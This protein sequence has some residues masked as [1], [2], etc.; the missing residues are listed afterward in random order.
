[1]KVGRNALA[2]LSM[3]A[4]GCAAAGAQ[5]AEPS[6]VPFAAHYDAQ[7]KG[8]N[9]GSSE[10]ELK[11]GTE[12]GQFVYVWSIAARGIFKIAYNHP[13]N[14]SSWFSLQNGHVRPHKYLGEDGSAS[15]RLDFDW[16]RKLIT[17][18]SEHKP[19]NIPIK[20]G[21][22]DLNSIQVEVMLDLKGGDLPRTFEIIDKDQLKEF[23]YTREGTAR[24]RTEVGTLDTLVVASQRTGNTR[25]LRMWFA[26][27][28]DFMP[29]QAERWRDGKLEFAMRI[30]SYRR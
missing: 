24:I 21:A 4:L 9:V 7:W 30:K 6:L 3:S 8:I 18:M 23:N 20:N 11:P 22:Q 17:G 13:V 2:T 14:Q 1:M 5:N 26:P 25:I 10:I 28:L 15:V 27:S 29:V 12:P 16:S 19:V